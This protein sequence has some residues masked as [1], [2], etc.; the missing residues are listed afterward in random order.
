MT[1]SHEY[2]HLSLLGNLL[3]VHYFV[4]D[5]LMHLYGAHIVHLYWCT[6]VYIIHT[7]WA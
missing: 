7:Y 3:T 6:I 2:E 5:E 4:S 1:R